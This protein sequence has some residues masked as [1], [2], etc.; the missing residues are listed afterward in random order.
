MEK[1]AEYGCDRCGETGQLQA[2]G[3]GRKGRDRFFCMACCRVTTGMP[4]FRLSCPSRCLMEVF[5]TEPIIPGEKPARRRGRPPSLVADNPKKRRC[6]ARE[7][8]S[9]AGPA[10]TKK[11]LRGDGTNA[12]ATSGPAAGKQTLDVNGNGDTSGAEAT[13]DPA[14]AKTALDVEGKGDTGGAQEAE[15]TSGPAVAKTASDVEGKGDTGGAQEAE[16]TSG[17]AAPETR[18]LA[19]QTGPLHGNGTSA[20]SVII[21]DDK[22]SDSEKDVAGAADATRAVKALGHEK[23]KWGANRTPE[24]YPKAKEDLEESFEQ[25]AAGGESGS[26]EDAS[27]TAAG[28]SDAQNV[29]EEGAISAGG[30]GLRKAAVDEEEGGDPDWENDTES[31]SE[32]DQE[33][34]PVTGGG[35]ANQRQETVEQFDSR[36]ELLSGK[37]VSI[38]DEAICEVDVDAFEAMLKTKALRHRKC[39]CSGGESTAHCH[40]ARCCGGVPDCPEGTNTTPY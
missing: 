38:E 9:D 13:S 5:A 25:F 10:T 6:I 18:T 30:I 40:G 14:V 23:N 15:A 32:V 34:E 31:E 27:R 36:N 2:Y 35:I 17:P 24:S 39:G 37:F 1:V 16:A 7:E 8:G 28:P 12:G 3:V 22:E 26:E 11:R 33:E 4:R 21:F 19:K 29:E 20:S